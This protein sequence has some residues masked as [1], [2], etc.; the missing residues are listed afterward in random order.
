MARQLP[1]IPTHSH[2]S[3]SLRVG[4]GTFVA[5]E[6][7][8]RAAHAVQLGIAAAYEAF[9]QVEK[10]M[11]PSRGGSD[12]AALSAAPPGSAVSLH[13][14][15]WQ[16]LELCHQVHRLSEGIFD[17]CLPES[18]GRMTDVELAHA[19][20]A[21]PHAP[22]RIDLGGIAKGFAVDRALD[23]LRASGCHAGLVNAGGDLA[24]FGDRS[25]SIVCRN[26]SGANASVALENAALAT[27]DVDNDARPAEHRG[28]Y[29]G[30][31]RHAVVSGRVSVVAPSAAIADALTKV[32]LIVNPARAIPL[33]EAFGARRIDI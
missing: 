19:N 3:S 23:A 24:V 13:P 11:H 12:L 33:L 32:L 29:H 28:Y 10:L 17:P 7:E 18:V 16:V 6:A 14:W 1:E 21:V 31:D 27:S 25:H 9:A 30:A 4:L 8:A 20:R 5:V 2:R 15:T 22:V 26:E